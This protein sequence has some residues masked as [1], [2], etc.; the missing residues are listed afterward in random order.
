MYREYNKNPLLP[1]IPSAPPWDP[2]ATAEGVYITNN[3]DVAKSYALTVADEELDLPIIVAIDIADMQ[4]QIDPQAIDLL[5]EPYQLYRQTILNLGLNQYRI[6]RRTLKDAGQSKEQMH[7]I[8]GTTYD[9][10]LGVVT[11]K[12]IETRPVRPE[13]ISMAGTEYAREKGEVA[14]IIFKEE[15]TW[16]L[17]HAFYDFYGS[18]APQVI[19]DYL[20]LQIDDEESPYSSSSVYV[21]NKK[22]NLEPEFW[23]YLSEYAFI[24]EPVMEKDI[25]AVFYLGAMEHLKVIYRRP[26]PARRKAY[27]GTG[28]GRIADAIPSL[29]GDFDVD[30][31]VNA[32]SEDREAK[33]NKAL[34]WL[35]GSHE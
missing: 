31:L 10:L 6:L 34:E 19:L 32:Y 33:F 4:L 21:S 5:Q 9:F 2:T 15:R 26:I 25:S 18:Q 12:S 29:F 11:D 1:K 13:F 23:Y 14:R 20:D 17:I 22:V 24:A 7:E 8:L 16:Y 35:R 30:T 28:Y 3:K 27:H